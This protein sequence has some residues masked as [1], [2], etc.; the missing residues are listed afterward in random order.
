MSGNERERLKIMAGVVEEEV[1]LI[2]ASGLMGVS[3]RQSKRIWRR[4]QDEGDAG[5][6]HRLRGKASARRKPSELREQVLTLCDEPRYEGF[7]PTLMAEQLLKAKLVV[8][9]ETLRRWRIAKGKTRCVSARPSTGNGGNAKRALGR[10]CRWT[11][12]T[13]TGSRGE[14]RSVC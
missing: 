3:Y 12:R 6:V 10:W 13:T 7:G 11:G 9:H 2:A 4:Y 5:L 1:T 14:G 8:D